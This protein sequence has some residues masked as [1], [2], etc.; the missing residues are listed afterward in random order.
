MIY[1]LPFGI[2]IG[3]VIG[4][5]QHS[6]M[7][8]AF[9]GNSPELSTQAILMVLLVVAIIIAY[10]LMPALIMQFFNEYRQA[11]PGNVDISSVW[12]NTTKTFGTIILTMLG[13]MG[14][15]AG[16]M[17]L[18]VL[19]AMINPWSMLIVFLPLLYFA[20]I[21]YF[22]FPIRIYENTSFGEALSRC[23]YLVN[24][25][26]WRTFLIYFVITMA[27]GIAAS[28]F[29]MPMY[30]YIFVKAYLST[31]GGSTDFS[32]GVMIATGIFAFAGQIILSIVPFIALNFQYFNL[33]EQKDKPGL[34]ERV[35][36]LLPQ[37]P[38]AN[39]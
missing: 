17:I 28:V 36:N 19:M 32:M 8:V 3:A 39:A 18:M 30:I 38:K 33:V 7:A 20:L 24:G 22:A 23:F 13:I 6:T 31:Q 16:A 27:V 12:A 29:V 34:M 11:G 26:W 14:I 35:N 1:L 5:Y 37:E 4:I 15:F 25:N 9:N 21:I 2:I 10:S